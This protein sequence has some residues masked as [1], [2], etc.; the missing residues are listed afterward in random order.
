M[1]K[2]ESS[3]IIRTMKLSSKKEDYLETIYR[4][5]SEIDTVGISDIARERGVTLPTA[6][7]AVAG[8]KEKGY[9][10]QRRYGKVILT[11]SGE[12]KAIAIYEAHKTIKRFLREILALPENLAESEACKMEHGL[13]G[14]TLE[15]LKKFITTVIDCRESKND[16]RTQ[17]FTL[18]K[19]SNITYDE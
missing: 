11:S 5:S 19:S 3:N 8:L 16:C 15:R 17:F 6:T 12:A 7:S 4:L 10:K 14:E 1:T 13:S 9:L 2:L 18:L